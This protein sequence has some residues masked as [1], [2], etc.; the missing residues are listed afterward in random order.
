MRSTAVGDGARLGKRTL[1]SDSQGEHSKLVVDDGARHAETVT[2][3]ERM[4]LFNTNKLMV[5]DDFTFTA[6]HKQRALALLDD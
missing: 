4:P 2:R 1:T 3:D 6:E 5:C